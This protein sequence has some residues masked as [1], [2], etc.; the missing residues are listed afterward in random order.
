MG[1]RTSCPRSLA[2]LKAP[3]SPADS[4]GAMSVAPRRNMV[5]LT[6][7][8]IGGGGLPLDL[9]T[10]WYRFHIPAAA[11][12]QVSN[13]SQK[14]GGPFGSFVKAGTDLLSHTTFKVSGWVALTNLHVWLMIVAAAAVT[15]SYLTYT[16]RMRGGATIITSGG[17]SAT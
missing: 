1:A 13:F 4:P 3:I 12:S 8:S 17:A 7:A 5:G 15:V 16:D 14:I 11:L 2:A 6:L 9:F 10:S